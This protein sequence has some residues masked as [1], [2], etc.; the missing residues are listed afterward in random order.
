MSVDTIFAVR[1]TMKTQCHKYGKVGGKT[2][3]KENAEKE[4]KKKSKI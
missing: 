2:K 3:N 4:K 1:E